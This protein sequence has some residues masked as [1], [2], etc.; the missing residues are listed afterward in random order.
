MDMSEA[1]DLHS[2]I[3]I[4]EPFEQ[5][6]SNLNKD[7]DFISLEILEKTNPLTGKLQILLVNTLGDEIAKSA[8]FLK[9]NEIS[10]FKE[11]IHEIVN[12]EFIYSSTN[13][14]SL[15]KLP[16]RDGEK[17]LNNWTMQGWLSIDDGKYSLGPK[18]VFE[19][20]S[21][22]MNEY[23]DKLIFCSLCEEIVLFKYKKCK[24]D[25]C[26]SVLH[27]YC[28]EKYYSNSKDGNCIECL[29]SF[30]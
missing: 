1:Q 6:I 16:K 9:D 21:F 11:I 28:A 26:T 3:G 24:S 27:V 19:L 15:C 20:G 25:S 18:T 29:N 30:S 17:C 13:A 23:E 8:T 4:Q 12:S 14:L 2:K 5:M 22:L 7:L 10:F